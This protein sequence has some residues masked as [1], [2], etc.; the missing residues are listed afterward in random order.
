MKK[1]LLVFAA[2][3][4]VF[5]IASQAQASFNQGD[6][7]RV[8]YDTTQNV[9][10][11]TA[12]DL[13]AISS[14]VSNPSSLSDSG[15]NISI[16]VSGSKQFGAQTAGT[17]TLDVAYFAVNATGGVGGN[18]EMWLSGTT[19]KTETNYGATAGQGTAQGLSS[20]LAFGYGLTVFNGGTVNAWLP[21]SNGNSYYGTMNG[22]GSNPGSWNTFYVSGIGD[23][24]I[25]LVSGGTV[26]QD[27]FDFSNLNGSVVTV[28]GILTL[29]STLNSS[30]VLTTSISPSAA[31]IPPSV[32]L[33][34]SGLLGLVGIRRRN[35]FNF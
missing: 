26:K 11:E 27:L 17:T 5:G 16:G 31:P 24:E 32:L 2:C 12:T 33:F 3:L 1:L 14:I 30:G 21:T 10:Y 35:L 13:G 20:M 29:S 9:T 22:G 23:G 28:N 8:V 15:Y 18:G 25:A 34:G 4:L 6:L 19:G 7:I